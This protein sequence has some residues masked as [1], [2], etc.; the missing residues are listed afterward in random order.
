MDEKIKILLDKINIDENS[1][2]YFSDAR[3]TKI[4]VNSILD[5][6]QVFIEKDTILPINVYQE[7][8]EKKYLL[9]EKASNITF[10]FTFKNTS[11]ED[12]LSYY[13][14]LLSLLKDKL[15]VLEIYQ[16]CLRIEND[17]LVLVVSNESELERLI[18]C[19]KEIDRFYSNLDYNSHIEMIVRHEQD[20]LEEIQKELD[21]VEYT[22][23]EKEEKKP[24]KEEKEKKQYRRE[25]KDP[26][27]INGRGIREDPIKIKTIIGEDN[28]VVV[29]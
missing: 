15:H 21:T 5:S 6:W 13:P 14:Y 20:I 12:Y 16:D 8:E 26:N 25:A 24:I 28:N 7:L 3:L 27:S 22:K 10:K 29:E 19:S 18:E 1:Y 2:Q 4:K 9:D 11:L 17:F 23:E